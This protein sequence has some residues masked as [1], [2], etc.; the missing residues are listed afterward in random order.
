MDVLLQNYFE[1]FSKS[2][3]HLLYSFEKVQKLQLIEEQT[4]EEDL[5]VWE[6][7][8]SRFAR[9]SDILI[10]KVFR[11]LILEKDPAFR[12]SVI[13]LLNLAEKFGWIESAA[14][15][16]RIR[17]LRNVAAHEYAVNDLQKMYT[18]LMRLTPFILQVKIDGKIV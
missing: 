2:R 12:G 1:Q 8:A 11:R 18:E 9:T 7:F 16:R 17:E 15:F 14:E 3:A 4:K 13:D 6:S 10:S 5:E